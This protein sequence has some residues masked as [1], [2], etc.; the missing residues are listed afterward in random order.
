MSMIEAR[1]HD[2]SFTLLQG[3]NTWPQ[4]RSSGG[5]A[6]AVPAEWAGQDRQEGKK[7]DA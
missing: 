3:E 1:Q 6:Q 4:P 2:V 5:F 7:D